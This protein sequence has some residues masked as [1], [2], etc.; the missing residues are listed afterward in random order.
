MRST[1][2]M[3]LSIFLYIYYIL[4][5][6]FVMQTNHEITEQTQILRPCIIR[7]IPADS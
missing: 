4:W 6:T 7:I 1:R 2:D 5:N 3:K